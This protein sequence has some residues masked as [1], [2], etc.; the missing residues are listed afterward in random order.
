MILITSVVVIIAVLL[1]VVSLFLSCGI[2]DRRRTCMADFKLAVYLREDGLAG[3][4]VHD[5]FVSLVTISC[6]TFQFRPNEGKPC[7]SRQA[8]NFESHRSQEF[9]GNKLVGQQSGNKTMR[10]GLSVTKMP[11]R[12]SALSDRHPFFFF[13]GSEDAQEDVF[14]LFSMRK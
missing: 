14:G 8:V 5:C 12:G 11:P 4:F 10:K 13:G 7:N 1:P 3:G 9:V 2:C 6:R